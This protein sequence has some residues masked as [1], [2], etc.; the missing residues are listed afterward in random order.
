MSSGLLHAQ[1]DEDSEAS[2]AHDLLG[3]LVSTWPR[4]IL[5]QLQASASQPR[6]ELDIDI[7]QASR[8]GLLCQIYALRA[9]NAASAALATLRFKKT[10]LLL[11]STK[12][13]TRYVMRRCWYDFGYFSC[14]WR[15]GAQ[16]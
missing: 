9:A 14:T 7:R 13:C 12:P 6:D 1:L 10:I 3:D 2:G 15:L 16:R 5:Y 4:C 11:H 8:D